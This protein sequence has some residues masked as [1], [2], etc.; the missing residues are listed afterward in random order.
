[1]LLCIRGVTLLIV[2]VHAKYS[3]ADGDVQL[4]LFMKSSHV[5]AD[6]SEWIWGAVIVP[7]EPRDKEHR[8]LAWRLN[9][10]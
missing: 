4:P 7:A 2:H 8:N 3:Q 1:M 10:W 5:L 9:R 6:P